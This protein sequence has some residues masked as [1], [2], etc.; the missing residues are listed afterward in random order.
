MRQQPSFVAL[1]AAL[2]LAC[3][4]VDEPPGAAGAAGT[5]PPSFPAL[6]AAPPPQA[7]APSTRKLRQQLTDWTRA[8]KSG[9]LLLR[10]TGGTAITPG[11][12]LET[13]VDI[14][15][16]GLLARAKVHQRFGN[17]GDRW[18]EGIYVFPLP[19][20]AAVDHMRI[21]TDVRV[22]EGKIQEKEQARNTYQR[23]KQEGRRA[24]LVEQERPN[25]FTT[26]VAN[27]PPGSEIGV[28]IE[29]QQSLQLD[30][31]EFSLRFPMVVAPRYIPGQELSESAGLGTAINTGMGWAPDTDRV[32][33]G[34]HITPPVR[35]PDAGPINPVEIRVDLAPGFE[36][37]RLESPYHE[38]VV[39][40]S[41]QRYAVSLAGVP[42][43][44]DRD[45]VLQW[46]PLPGEEPTAA[47]FTEVLGDRDYALLMVTPPRLPGNRPAPP[48][49]E[50]VYVIDTSGSM[51]GDSLDQAKRALG[52]A[53]GRLRTGD[54]FNV[55]QFSSITESLSPQSLTA[56]RANVERA[57]QYVESLDANGGTEI[58]PAIQ[59]ALAAH[60]ARQ[61]L[62]RQVVFLTDGSVGNE[63]E[64]FE[65]IRA[66][67]GESRLFTIGI[68]SAPNSH[69]M[70][71]TAQMGRGSFTHIGKPEEVAEKMT[72][73]FSKL[74]AV[75]LTDIE[76]ELPAGD[77]AELYPD[78]I[79][80][81]YLSEPAVFALKL[82]EPLDWLR[83]RGFR[84]HEPWQA[85]LD[86]MDTEDRRGVHVLWARRKI[87]ALM[88]A[89]LGERDEGA[90]HD[91]RE[92]VVEV[93]L[94]HHLV[95]SYTSLV[96]V[97]I[98]PERRGYEELSAHALATNLPAGWNFESVFGM[99]K[100][101]TTA[102][103]RM[104]IGLLLV[105]AG[106]A[107]WFG[108]IGWAGRGG[109][110]GLPG[111]G[112]RAGRLALWLRGAS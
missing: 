107:W 56:S 58:L 14:T 20:D 12:V 57:L 31:G 3:D 55:I 65:A 44:A 91:L 97:D 67:L 101:A 53:L 47:L 7:F 41:G 73:L 16:T 35:H 42:V 11:P 49:R 105:L 104:A 61:R 76:L 93:A 10:T 66:S 46:T 48:P 27:I 110:F 86:T 39:S 43:P 28:E 54:S 13:T 25:V 81:L 92:A 82:D 17:P 98:T 71:K 26:H 6:I 38:I 89:R 2:A 22:I 30:Q 24:S 75:V 8:A 83:V 21:Y 29:Y 23:A 99:A 33:D 36:L 4:P 109:R 100:T 34:S 94:E 68:G 112:G 18:A 85:E 52:M 60:G 15:V 32:P 84:G 1:A 5:D 88:D 90:L 95:S 19:D 79:S 103:L 9:T 45:F 108:F 74:E 37:D 69:F 63:K 111:R 96:A 72:G 80:D 50:I 106:F 77:S 87:A 40:E 70:R 62:L 102:D 64:L 59:R 78:G 51:A